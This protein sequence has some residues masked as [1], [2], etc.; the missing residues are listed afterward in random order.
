M[1][2]ERLRAMGLIALTTFLS[3]S[4]SMAASL[5][6][7]QDF[8]SLSDSGTFTTDS[9]PSGVQLTNSGSR[10]IGGAGLD[11]ATTWFDTRGESFGPV[12]SG[13]TGDFIGV[14]S[15]SLSNAPDV[16]P[17]G[18]AVA[19][20]LEHNFEFNDGDGALVLNFEAVDLSGFT[21]RVLSLKY[22]INSTGYESNDAFT[23]SISNGGLGIVLLGYG[24]TELEA[25]ASADDG[26]NNWRTLVVDLDAVLSS[27]G[28][29]D[30]N[31]ILSV[32]VDTNSA[33]EN[34]FLDEIRF[35]ADAVIPINVDVRPMSC[36]N[37]VN[38]K[39]KGIISVAVLGTS[40][41]DVTKI[42]PASLQLSG[43]AP[44]RWSYEDVATPYTGEIADAYNCHALGPDGYDDL[45]LK[46]K[47]QE[48]VAALGA[49]SD[50][51][52][53]VVDVEGN[54]KAEFGSTPIEGSD[55]IIVID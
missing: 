35:E 31:V 45:V 10:N 11:F 53:L 24:E 25:N 42:D 6:A 1:N 51:D 29:S 28:L 33:Q 36:P 43:V 23:I 50:R 26:T 18:A 30:T 44:L 46:F 21:D 34:V 39:S 3:T 55:V 2:I 49:V 22:W 47:T 54:L 13:E 4:V 9:L 5:I 27:S 37:P 16:G 52:V 41:F 19:S 40:E 20:T 38:T 12:V 17:G 15:F 14:N 7:A 8:N 48:F 32:A